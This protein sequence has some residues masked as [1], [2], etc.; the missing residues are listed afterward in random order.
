MSDK[1]NP[2]PHDKHAAKA[3]KAASAGGDEHDGLDAGLADSF[4]ASAPQVPYCQILRSRTG[5]AERPA[6]STGK[7]G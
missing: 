4:P 2:A 6:I 5:I 3:N 7:C 1:F